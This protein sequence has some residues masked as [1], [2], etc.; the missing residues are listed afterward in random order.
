[1]AGI[2]KYVKKIERA[3]R[4]SEL[5]KLK[6]AILSDPDLS[7]G[8]VKVLIGI[9]LMP[10]LK[11]LAKG[12]EIYMDSATEA[13]SELEG[14]VDS[15]LFEALEGYLL[16]EAPN[17]YKSLESLRKRVLRYIPAFIKYV[18]K[19]KKKV[20]SL[21]DLDRDKLKTFHVERFI[22]SR[23]ESEHERY[24]I[25]SYLNA[26]GKWLEENYRGFEFPK[27]KKKRPRR[28]EMPTFL[29][30]ELKERKDK[31]TVFLRRERK[32]VP[33]N[34]SE[35]DKVFSAWD[36]IT[37]RL[38]PLRREQLRIYLRLLLQTGLRP[39]HALSL[40]VEDLLEENISY[41]EDVWG[42]DFVMVAIAKALE[43]ER[44]AMGL[45]PSDIKQVPEVTF[46][47]ADLYDNIKKMIDDFDLP[48]D[49]LLCNVPHSTQKDK[50]VR[51]RKIT[52][53]DF[54]RYDL[55]ETWAS[56]V[57]NATGYD[58]KLV[59]DLG[60]WST[61]NI[62]IQVYIATM[63]P[64][65]AVRI[66]KKYEIFIPK[67]AKA[68]VDKIERGISPKVEALMEKIRRLEEKLQKLTGGGDEEVGDLE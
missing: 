29:I 28:K 2:T 5:L 15:D 40:R 47:S 3:N 61:A 59:K 9:H 56:V 35:L 12:K 49:A 48:V 51:V 33:R 18:H 8:D 55:R 58:L 54:N 37:E 60:G 38:E 64:E 16:V 24:M 13:L 26:F 1:M 19:S 10:K 57:Y 65:E 31:A 66:A 67:S 46:I 17:R 36:Y 42:R 6:K 43:R 22:D 7:E 62:P 4:A 27:V 53:I 39:E 41:I 25:A 20:L 11:K 30:E 21:Q 14:I 45:S 68:A 32:G 52:G 50:I 63:S 34:L 44:V 23:T